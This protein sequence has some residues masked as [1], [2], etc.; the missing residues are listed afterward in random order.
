MPEQDIEL[1]QKLEKIIKKHFASFN[2]QEIYIL[3]Q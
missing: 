1:K 2:E 3:N